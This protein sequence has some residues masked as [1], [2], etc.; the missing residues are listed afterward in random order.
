MAV[1]FKHF[2]TIKSRIKGD[3]IYKADPRIN[4][5][6]GCFPEP[7]NTHSAHA[8]IVKIKESST[9]HA[10]EQTAGHVPD[11][12]AEILYQPV[13]DGNITINSKITGQ[14]RSAPEGTWVQ[15]GGLEIPCLYEVF[16]RSSL[17]DL[18]ASLKEKLSALK[19][20]ADGTA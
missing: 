19:R 18:K 7:G 4:S 11:S 6:C 1:A 9:H 10:A 5:T 15:G 13:V 20:N 3:H 12:L 17:S 16:L 2:Y 8:I 14:S